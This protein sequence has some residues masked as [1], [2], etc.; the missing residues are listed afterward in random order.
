MIPDSG[1]ISPLR[2]LRQRLKASGRHTSRQSLIGALLLML[3]GAALCV[4]QPWLPLLAAVALLGL[5]VLLRYLAVAVVVGFVLL[6]AFRLHELSPLLL[7]LRLPQL[8]A[9]L[10]LLVL[11][12]RLM[13]ERNLTPFLLAEG[14]LLLALFGV[15]VLGALLA[16]NSGLALNYLLG[17]WIK[18]VLMCFACSWLLQ[19]QRHID[20]LSWGIIIAGGVVALVAL[21]NSHHGLELV[22]GSRVTIGRS[23]GSMLGDPNDLAL[24][25]LLPFSFALSRSLQRSQGQWLATL[26]VL[27]LLAAM[28][29]TQSRGG[30]LG[31]AAISCL[32]LVRRFRLPRW[33]WA[34]A[35]L[36]LLLLLSLAGIAERQSGGAAESGI[37]ESALGRLYAWQAAFSMMLANPLLG[38]GLD[39]FYANYYFHSPHWDGKNHAVHSSWFQVMAE[40]GLSGFILF[41]GFYLLLLRRAFHLLSHADPNGW[42]LACFAGVVGFGIGG[43]FLTQAFT[44]PLYI[45]AALIWA[46]WR[47]TS[48]NGYANCN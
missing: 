8:L 42:H 15:T 44:W 3:L 16:S 37:D 23:Y 45:M 20:W 47:I 29:A 31:L 34:L 9:L 1:A 5:L 41:V 43:T 24:V 6:S 4:A 22:E 12:W 48:E 39:N 33:L 7:P 26:V 28:L 40:A 11:G 35:P 19:Q 2:G 13:I 25:L 46:Q 32:L 14:K 18:V 27:L 17:S 36:L 21:Y 10:A 38:V 30:L